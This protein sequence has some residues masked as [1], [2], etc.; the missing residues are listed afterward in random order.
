MH[1]DTDVQQPTRDAD[2]EQTAD[3]ADEKL[4]TTA[5]HWRQTA[6]GSPAEDSADEVARGAERAAEQPGYGREGQ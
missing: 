4:E 6:E 5:D 3:E 2:A 1:D